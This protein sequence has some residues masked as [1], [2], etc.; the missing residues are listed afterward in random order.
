LQRKAV[1]GPLAIAVI[2]AAYSFVYFTMQRN[3]SAAAAV[4]AERPLTIVLD[5]GH[6]GEDGGAVSVSGV[7]ESRINLEITQR[8]EQVFALCGMKTA[9]IRSDDTSVSSEGDSVSA[10]KNSDLRNRVHFVQQS[11][12]AILIS[13]HQNHFSDGKYDGAQVFYAKTSGS[14][15]LAVMLQDELRNTLNPTNHRTCKQAASVYL[16]DKITCTGVLV[17]CGFLSNPKEE[18]LLQKDDYQTKIACAIGSAVAKYME[19]G[20]Y[21]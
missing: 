19:E 12:P 16:L 2:I 7:K 11:E 14:K 3:L 15:E 1:L 18:M 6:G 9:L 4:L 21:H 20:E 17:E 10:R 8:L 13:I 5:A